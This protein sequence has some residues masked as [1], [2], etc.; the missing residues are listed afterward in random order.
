[1]FINMY[2]YVFICLFIN[3][4]VL[5]INLSFQNGF[6]KQI[7]RTSFNL[8]LQSQHEWTCCI[9]TATVPNN[10]QQFKKQETKTTP[11]RLYF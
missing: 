3:K 1:M 10:I 2:L 9:S 11:L 4:Y 8:S 6:V 7:G 5:A